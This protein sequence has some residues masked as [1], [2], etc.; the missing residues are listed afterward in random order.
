[1]RTLTVRRRKVLTGCTAKARVY[2]EDPENPEITIDR[3]PCRKLG[4]LKNGGEQSFAIG[5]EAAKIYVIADR[6]TKGLSGEYFQLP[7]G[8]E[9]VVLTGQYQTTLGGGLFQFDN[10]ETADVLKARKKKTVIGAIILVVALAVGLSAGRVCGGG[11]ARKLVSAPKDFSSDGMTIT[12]DKGF[13]ED[14][15]LGFT[16][17]YRSKDVYVLALKEAFDSFPGAEQLSLEEYGKIILEGNELTD[18]QLTTFDGIPGF[19]YENFDEDS[20][21]T[22]HDRTFL[23]K[24][25]DAFWMIQFLTYKETFSGVEKEINGWAKTVRFEQ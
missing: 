6:L 15:V 18:V 14:S 5:D 11:A 16:A 19:E 2:I 4:E 24:T 25:D 10:N 3:T 22:F 20:G 12:L 21:D 13:A 23:Y 9:D 17:C 8:D 7:E 1:M